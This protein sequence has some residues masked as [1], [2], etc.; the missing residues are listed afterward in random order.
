MNRFLTLLI[1]C[2]WTSA[3][4]AATATITWTHPTQR[5]NGVSLALSEIKQTNIDYGICV[6][7]ALPATPQTVVVPAPATTTTITGLGYGTWCF[8]GQT[9]DTGLLESVNSTVAQKVILAPPKPPVLG[10]IA[11]TAYELNYTGSGVR[12]GR[13]VG[14]VPLGTE[15]A[16]GQL[17]K[18]GYYEIPL[19][20]VELSRMP[21]SAVVVARCEIS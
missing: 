19:D 3:A 17:V 14:T 20:K 7:S 9:V 15:C 5:E 10:T 12:L 13:N 6:G 1:A 4:L 2:L 8:A 21:K 11:I 16:P 18:G